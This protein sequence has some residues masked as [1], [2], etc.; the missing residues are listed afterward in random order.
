MRARS[1]I[2]ND[3]KILIH[4]ELRS[5]AR[6]RM[7]GSNRLFSD[8]AK[9]RTDLLLTLKEAKELRDIRLLVEIELNYMV[10]ELEFLAHDADNIRSL[11]KG[12]FVVPM[13][14]LFAI[15]SINIVHKCRTSN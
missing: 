14:S 6:H 15:F 9:T 13:I 7:S 3:P 1:E 2:F 12:I 4:N 10:L 11:Q 5:I 8:I